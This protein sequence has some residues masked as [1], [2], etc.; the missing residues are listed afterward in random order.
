MC[1][2]DS[3]RMVNSVDK[4]E[5]M[6]MNK[7]ESRPCKDGL[8]CPY[9]HE[10]MSGKIC[11][12]QGYLENGICS[13]FNSGCVHKHPWN[14]DKHGPK[15]ALLDKLRNASKRA[16]IHSVNVVVSECGE[17]EAGCCGEGGVES[18]GRGEGQASEYR[19]MLRTEP[20]PKK[21][22]LLYTS[23]SPRD[24]TRS[25]MPSSA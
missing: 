22:C 19:K 23:P 25:R 21:L 16:F 11:T 14:E 18:Q 3:D 15:Q 17:R 9:G 24:R 8:K 2:R 7:R 6:C 10:G 12:D 1:I 4:A 20:T 5:Q 13:R